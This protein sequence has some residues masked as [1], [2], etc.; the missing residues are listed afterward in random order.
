MTTNQGEY[1]M[2]TYLIII[3]S[4][5]IV[6]AGCSNGQKV[7][8]D[9]ADTKWHLEQLNGHDLIPTLHKE[10]TIEIGDEDLRGYGGC[11]YFGSHGKFSM[12]SNRITIESIESSAKSCSTEIDKQETAFYRALKNA[13]TYQ[14]NGNYLEFYNDSNELVLLF[15]K[16]E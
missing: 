7:N 9:I 10:I 12:K 11:N 3:L 8:Q 2:K 5:V 15:T 6:V 1:V 16:I 14:L 4:L 13:K